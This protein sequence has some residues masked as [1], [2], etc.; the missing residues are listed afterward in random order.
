VADAPGPNYTMTM[1]I[2]LP[3]AQREW[4][5][6]QV[7]Q[8]QFA[9]VEDAV[10]Q[11]IAERMALEADDLAWAKPLVDEARKAVARGE[12]MTLEEHRSRMAKRLKAL[13]I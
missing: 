4:L 13:G 3:P 9:S 1:N 7:A 8:G 2:A 6:A 11:M 12:V 5:E 10:R